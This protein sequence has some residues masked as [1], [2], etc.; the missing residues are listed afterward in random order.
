MKD[1]DAEKWAAVKKDL[2][3]ALDIV[4]EKHNLQFGI[5]RINALHNRRGRTY[6]KLGIYKRTK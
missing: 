1:F 3:L 2:E 4:G 5:G 6:T